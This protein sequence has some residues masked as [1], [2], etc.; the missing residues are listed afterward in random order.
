[1]HLKYFLICIFIIGCIVGSMREE[2]KSN[3]HSGKITQYT[4]HQ[5]REHRC[6][7]WNLMHEARG[8]GT[9]G[10]L[11]VA[12]VVANRVLSDK[13]PSTVCG[14]VLQKNQFSWTRDKAKVQ[15]MFSGGSIGFKR[16]V[17]LQGTKD[18]LAYQRAV[19][20]ASMSVLELSRMVPRGGNKGTM[21]YAHRRVDNEWTRRMKVKYIVKNHVFYSI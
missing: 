20:I 13:Y 14:V 18:Y 8:E 5:Q 3:V 19:Q 1:M 10:M 12:N 7:L 21:H 4:Q 2:P 16:S 6:M 17:Q 11:A 9:E 15:Q